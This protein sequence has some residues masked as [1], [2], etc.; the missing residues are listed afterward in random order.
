MPM[1][2]HRRPLLGL[3]LL[4]APLLAGPARAQAPDSLP[5]FHWAPIYFHSFD[6]VARAAGLE[7][8]RRA[9]LPAGHRE[10]R[11]W[12]QVEIGAP[13]DLYRF[14]DRRGRV[15]GE[16][17]YHWPAPPPDTANG[18]RP[19]ETFHDL[20]VQTLRGRC[21]QFAVADE[22]GVCRARFTRAP[23]WG[24]VLRAAEAGGLWD[25]PDPS[26]LP[27]DDVMVFDGWTI[28]VELRDAR[29]YRT[30]RYNS[31]EAHP[32]WPSAA[33][34]IEVARAL[35]GVDALLA[36]SEARRL[37]RGVT[38][39]RYESAFRPCGER[40]EWE[41]HT[42][43]E[44][45]AERAPPAVKAA[46]RAAVGD[47][48]ARPAGGGGREYYVEVIGELTPA[49]LARRWGSKFERALQASE[50]RAVLPWT[51]AECRRPPAAPR[52][53]R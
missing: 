43:L 15:A 12:T 33:R 53:G 34:V 48:A 51:G 31:P 5:P 4:L 9:R 2:T 25:L 30:Y 49:W 23:R 8:L 39:G 42:S 21:D 47:S 3:A 28:V 32:T 52:P 27:P 16:L 38:T 7:P 46:L 50:L 18:E 35:R 19:G 37:Y 20:M 13:K 22:T 44:G 36:P 24:D 40:A 45:L 26:A 10:V 14:V 29:G 1:L 17:I 6:R 11:I 41:F